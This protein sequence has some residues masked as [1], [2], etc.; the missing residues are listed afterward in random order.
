M[1]RRR[2]INVGLRILLSPRANLTVKSVG[3]ALHQRG[4]TSQHNVVVK[5]DLQVTIALLNR[6]ERNLR[7]TLTVLLALLQ[8]KRWVENDLGCADALLHVDLDVPPSHQ[9]KQGVLQS[10]RTLM[11]SALRAV[12]GLR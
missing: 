2:H 10:P 1:K 6:V 8:S 12:G 11:E 7:N 3:E 5:I 9:Q 4:A